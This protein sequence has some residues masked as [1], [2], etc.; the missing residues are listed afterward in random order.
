MALPYRGAFAG[1]ADARHAELRPIRRVRR[2]MGAQLAVDKAIPC[3]HEHHR[4]VVV[5][6]RA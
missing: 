5:Q 6:L 3:V 1:Q 2:E 4:V